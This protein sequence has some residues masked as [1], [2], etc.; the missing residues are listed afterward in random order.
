MSKVRKVFDEQTSIAPI[1]FNNFCHAGGLL[2]A[3]SVD[4]YFDEFPSR[5]GDGFACFNFCIREH[6]FAFSEER[7]IMEALQFLDQHERRFGFG[8]LNATSS[9]KRSLF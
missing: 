5:N 9:F 1:I 6:V 7:K 3:S 8:V 2:V 4:R